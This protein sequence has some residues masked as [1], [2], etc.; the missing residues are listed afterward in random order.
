M[1]L[2][3][4][5]WDRDLKGASQKDLFEELCDELVLNDD[6]EVALIKKVKDKLGNTYHSR[7]DWETMAK[8]DDID[9]VVPYAGL[10]N[11]DFAIHLG[12]PTHHTMSDVNSYFE[13]V[14]RHF[15]SPHLSEITLA[16]NHGGAAIYN[17]RNE[18]DLCRLVDNLTKIGLAGS[19]QELPGMLMKYSE[20]V[21][22]W[23]VTRD[24]RDPR[25]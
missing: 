15:R 13:F 9:E 11:R 4:F 7:R 19:H 23:S 1:R 3:K 20:D 8:E 5:V 6:K 22:R 12:L 17:R 24:F 21:L 25:Q 14:P 10:V 2:F 16:I 18:N